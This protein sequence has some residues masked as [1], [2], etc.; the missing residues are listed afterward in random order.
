MGPTCGLARDGTSR[1]IIDCAAGSRT[2]VGLL[3][4]R[5]YSLWP[6]SPPA[7]APRSLDATHNLEASR[8][9]KLIDV[10]RLFTT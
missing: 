4:R 2:K 1:S 9:Q 6:D 3:G 8:A 5:A 7:E 10:V